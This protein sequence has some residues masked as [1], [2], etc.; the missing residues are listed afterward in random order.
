MPA[1]ASP[2]ASWFDTPILDMARAKTD[3]AQEALKALVRGQTLTP[4][5]SAA[6]GWLLIVVV[7]LLLLM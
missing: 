4:P 7:V 6:L 2:P 5:Q 3:A 1:P